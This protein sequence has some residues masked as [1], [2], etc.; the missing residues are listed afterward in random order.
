[1]QQADTTCP[2]I[3]YASIRPAA[4]SFSADERALSRFLL[5]EAAQRTLDRI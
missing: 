5:A 2:R 3:A 1:M 4:F